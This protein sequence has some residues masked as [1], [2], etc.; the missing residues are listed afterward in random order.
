MQAAFSEHVQHTG[1]FREHVRGEFANS[2][3]MGNLQEM[4]HQALAD[5]LALILVDDGKRHLGMSRTQYD[6]A[7]ASHNSRPSVF[8]HYRDQSHVVDEIN[9]GKRFDLLLSKM[10]PHSEKSAVER[11]STGAVDCCEKPCPVV[12]L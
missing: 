4:P 3:R 8:L 12:R 1:V 9:V 5:T 6:V 7:C 10:A 2:G 11:L